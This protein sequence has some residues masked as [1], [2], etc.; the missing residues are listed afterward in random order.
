MVRDVGLE[1]KYYK[2]GDDGRLSIFAV[3]HEST[4][5]IFDWKFGDAAR[6]ST[7]QRDKNEQHGT[8]TVFKYW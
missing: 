5:R 6:M 7:A 4:G 3:Y 8:V 1:P 2:R